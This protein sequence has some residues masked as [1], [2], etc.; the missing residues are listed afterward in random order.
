MI[1]SAQDFVRLR[2]SE[3][4]EEQHRATHEEAAESVWREVIEGFPDMREW[5]AHNKTVPVEILE[6]LSR[7]PD[8]RV[9]YAVAMKRKIPEEMQLVLARD[10]DESV[11]RRIAY[12][13]KATKRAL[14]ILAAD[15]E[16]GI[17]ERALKRLEEEDYVA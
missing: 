5:V 13:A 16:L 1:K 3:L 4:A 9:R 6:E 12:N 15:V 17:R 2:N 11:R 8:S 14:Q 7:D 10:T